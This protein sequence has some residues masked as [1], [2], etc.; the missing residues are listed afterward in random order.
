MTA[1]FTDATLKSWSTYYLLSK[2]SDALATLLFLI[3]FL[4]VPKS[5]SSWGSFLPQW[6]LSP[7]ILCYPL[8][9]RW[10]SWLCSTSGIVASS[11]SL[12]YLHILFLCTHL[13]IWLVNLNS[14]FAF[15]FTLKMSLFR[16]SPQ[17]AI[18]DVH[19]MMNHRQIWKT[20]AGKNS[21]G[22]QRLLIGWAAAF[23]TGW[24]V[25]GWERNLPSVVKWFYFLLKI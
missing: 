2:E 25:A 20:K 11:P 15:C 9:L 16:N 18:E 4:I 23:F 24:A 3:H 7:I 19:A 13:V 6:W 12:L 10:I 22:W 14:K 1:V 5:P 21:S 17:I 8:L